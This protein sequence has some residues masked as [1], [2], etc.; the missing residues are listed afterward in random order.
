MAE[1]DVGDTIEIIC[2]LKLTVRGKKKGELT[3]EELEQLDEQ[4]EKGGGVERTG[5]RVNV[6][7][8]LHKDSFSVEYAFQESLS[9]R[10]LNN[11]KK[12]LDVITDLEIIGLSLKAED[13]RA[14]NN[15]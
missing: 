8:T 14:I 12:R 11:L 1:Y 13:F 3:S 5:Q 2:A 15:G 10:G 6:T 7:S 4:V 9:L